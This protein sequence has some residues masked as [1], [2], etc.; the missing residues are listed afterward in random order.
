MRFID[1]EIGECF[2][3][4]DSYFQKVERIGYKTANCIESNHPH[5]QKGRP[6]L[7]GAMEKV[8]HIVFTGVHE[9]ENQ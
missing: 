3:I 4:D 8:K 7:I 9:M 2:E 6:Y 1:L 5:Y